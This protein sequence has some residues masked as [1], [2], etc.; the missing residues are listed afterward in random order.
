MKRSDIRRYEQ[1]RRDINA[2]SSDS[3]IMPTKRHTMPSMKR[4]D[5]R[6]YK[7]ARRDINASSADNSYQPASPD[8]IQGKTRSILV[9]D[10]QKEGDGRP[11][12]FWAQQHRTDKGNRVGKV[13]K[14]GLPLTT[15]TEDGYVDPIKWREDL[16]REFKAIDEGTMIIKANPHPGYNCH[17]YTFTNGEGGRLTAQDVVTILEDHEYEPIASNRGRWITTP[18]PDDVII[19]RNK[20]TSTTDNIIHSG[21]VTRVEGNKIS[22][23]NKWGEEGVVEHLIEDTPKEFGEDWT[24]YHTSRPEGRRVAKEQQPSTQ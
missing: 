6:R 8:L 1:A 3:H 24:I 4:S 16:R 15:N 10:A 14:E 18:V 23:E 13:W 9:T 2:S 19:F 22:I 11:Q 20:G 12:F 21:F 5:I 17:G 7:Q